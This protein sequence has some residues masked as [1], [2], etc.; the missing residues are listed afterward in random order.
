[1]TFDAVARQTRD[2]ARSLA[3]VQPLPRQQA[4]PR[5]PWRA[6]LRPPSCDGVSSGSVVCGG[7]GDVRKCS[8]G[9]GGTTRLAGGGR[10]GEAGG[11]S[12]EAA[13]RGP[14]GRA[15]FQRGPAAAGFQP[16]SASPPGPRTSGRGR[17]GLAGCPR[18]ELSS[19][20]GSEAAAVVVYDDAGAAPSV[21]AAG[22]PRHALLQPPST[23]GVRGFC[24][25]RAVHAPRQHQPEVVKLV[26]SLW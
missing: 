16:P 18:F 19:G 24:G 20:A 4:A 1:M 9:E 25:L 15:L 10:G 7:P 6:W 23:Q 13:R 21:G 2:A 22:S 11:V 3:R 12:A 8:P 5:S 17:R 14:C 26:N